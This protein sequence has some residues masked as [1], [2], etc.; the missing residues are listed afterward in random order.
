[1]P[2]RVLGT[3]L[4]VVNMRLRIPFRYGIVT[5]TELPHVILCAEVEIEGDRHVG[6]AA[7]HLALKWFTKNPESH[8]R[9]DL[10]EMRRVIETAC[11]VARAAGGWHLCRPPAAQVVHE[12]SQHVVPPGRGGHVGRDRLRLRR[13][14]VDRPTP[15]G[16]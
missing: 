11:D 10:A 9:D 3:E 8:A 16:L 4:R 14:G 15:H 5:V 6:L 12:G 13:R 7:D 2:L 1:M